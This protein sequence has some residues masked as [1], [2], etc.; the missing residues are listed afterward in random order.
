MTDE[1]T[2]APTRQASCQDDYD[3][4]SLSVDEARMRMREFVTPITGI[5][6]VAVRAALGR[7][8]A[9]SVR[10]RFPVPQHTNAAMDGYAIRGDSLP[11][12]GHQAFTEIGVSLAGRPFDG[13][14]G[15]DQCVRITTGAVVPEGADTVVMQEHV[16]R[17]KNNILID[18]NHKAGQNVRA[19]GEDIA[20]GD[21]VLL[22]GHRM[23]PA[24]L[25]LVASL[26]LTEVG[27]RR[28]LRV[29]FFSTGDELRSLGEPLAPG[30]IYDSNR[31]TL[32]GMLTAMGAEVVDMGVVRDD[33]QAL[34]AAFH[35]AGA[36]AD[37]VITSGGVSV[38]EADYTR[39]VLAAVGEVAL[40]KVAMKPGRPMAF[41][42]VGEAVFFGLPGNPVSVMVTFYQFVQPVL[43]Q[44]LGAATSLI[45]TVTARTTCRLK[46][47]PGRVEFQR[48]VLAR[49]EDGGWTVTPTGDQGSGIL[50]SMSEANAFIVL[51]TDS[52]GVDVGMTVEVQPFFGV[53][54]G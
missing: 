26:G 15:P 9:E 14:V 28:K 17:D 24:D 27:V 8:L 40:W 13:S 7:V 36:I 1:R 33:E 6:R 31:Y 50:T 38:G 18:N 4:E 23:T 49:G 25:G 12:S 53:L 3:P 5:E 32:W 34:V 19:A 52:R 41:G 43:R 10:A 45:P 29:A 54:D 35:E 39:Q 20:P 44:M 11:P 2:T 16:A 22:V 37:V 46:K 21:D 51:D 30:T 47:R 42:R 48:G